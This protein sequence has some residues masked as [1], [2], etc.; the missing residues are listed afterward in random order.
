MEV[1]LRGPKPGRERGFCTH[2]PLIWAP[3]PPPKQPRA[4]EL[5]EASAR[6]GTGAAALGLSDEEVMAATAM[7][8]TA[9]GTAEAEEIRL[10][11]RSTRTP[12][13]CGTSAAK[14]S[15]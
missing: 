15:A 8:A 12:T 3:P 13:C 14:S 6:A 1:G 5:L 2:N 10:P 9:T 11:R 7:A 4:E